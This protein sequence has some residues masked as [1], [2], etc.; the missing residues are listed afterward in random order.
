MGVAQRY[1]T[2]DE[3][4]RGCDEAERECKKNKK[5]IVTEINNNVF[6]REETKDTDS[7][8]SDRRGVQIAEDVMR[9]TLIV[10]NAI[11]SWVSSVAADLKTKAA[12]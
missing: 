7:S 8:I 2:A 12:Q 11:K 1:A 6:A 3:V 10:L 5:K 4:E 9:R